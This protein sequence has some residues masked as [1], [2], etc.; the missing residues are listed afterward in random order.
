MNISLMRYQLICIAIS[1]RWNLTVAFSVPKV[2]PCSWRI[3]P[4]LLKYAS[5]YFQ[6]RPCQIFSPQALY[7]L[8]VIQTHRIILL[9]LLVEFTGLRLIRIHLVS[10]SLF[11]QSGLVVRLTFIHVYVRRVV[12]I[13]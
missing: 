9:R 11:S 12:S 10:L 3:H 2:E 7:H 13:N 6:I 1:S 4:S 5:E 8:V